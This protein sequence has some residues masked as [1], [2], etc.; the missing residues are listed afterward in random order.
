MSRSPNYVWSGCTNLIKELTTTTPQPEKCQKRRQEWK[1]TIYQ[2][3]RA[4]KMVMLI[5][6]SNEL[7]FLII[8]IKWTIYLT[9]ITDIFFNT[10]QFKF[11]SSCICLIFLKSYLV[12][13]KNLWYSQLKQDNCG[14]IFLRN[15]TLFECSEFQLYWKSFSHIF[16]SS[17]RIW[18]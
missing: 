12:Y 6:T 13:K 14:D 10:F 8:W 2:R 18:H 17:C 4:M 5:S 3:S 7:F 1:G 15:K 9:L 11:V 16:T